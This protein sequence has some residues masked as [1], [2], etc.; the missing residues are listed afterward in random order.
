MEFGLY[1]DPVVLTQ[2]H[3]L[4]DSD[5]EEAENEEEKVTISITDSEVSVVEGGVLLVGVGLT[6]SIFAQSYPILAEGATCSILANSKAVLKDTYFPASGTGHAVGKK[7][8]CDDTFCLSEVFAVQSEGTGDGG[9][10]FVC[11]HE[12]PLKPEYCNTWASKVSQIHHMVYKN[13]MDCMIVHVNDGIYM[14]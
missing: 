8:V 12:K 11:V 2:R 1:V 6:A 4:Y 5:E 10:S 14:Y 3:T 9:N 7:T 13:I